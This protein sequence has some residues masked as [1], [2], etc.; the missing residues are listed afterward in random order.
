MRSR[1]WQ[2]DTMLWLQRRV[3]A[4][5]LMIIASSA[6]ALTQACAGA[7]MPNNSQLLE[8]TGGTSAVGTDTATGGDTSVTTNTDCPAGNEGCDC[9]GNGTCNAGLVCASRL[10]V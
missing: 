1:S 9:Y 2:Q 8:D 3:P 10:C 5:R 6:T 7:P 4:I